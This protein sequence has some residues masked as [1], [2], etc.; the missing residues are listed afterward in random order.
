MKSR[1]LIAT[2]LF[3]GAANVFSAPTTSILDFEVLRHDDANISVHGPEYVEDGFRLKA[4]HSEPGNPLRLNTLGTLQPGFPGSTALYQ[5]VVLGEIILTEVDGKPFDLLSIQLAELPGLDT[6]GL[7]INS[8]PFDVT[9]FGQ[10]VDGS[11]VTKT[12]IVDGFLTLN[13]YSFSGFTD[14]LSVNWFQGGGDIP[15]HQFDNITV[16]V[17]PLTVDI[18]IKPGSDPNCFNTNGH[19]VI[20]VAILGNDNFDVR[21]IDQSSLSFSGQEVR[22]RGNKGP[23]CGEEDSNSDGF[24][25][26]VCHFEDDSTNWSPGSFGNATLTGV[27]LDGTEFEGTD[28]ICIVL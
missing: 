6:S 1:L 13:T 5:G 24:F 23:L 16:A 19:G 7:P 25:D 11:L 15:T 28:S 10:Q 22:M 17:T 14:L 21:N 12:F 3:L 26:L 9:F 4:Q 18:D 2:L 27:M 8:G 20:P